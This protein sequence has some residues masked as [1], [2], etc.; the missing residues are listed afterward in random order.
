MPLLCL[1]W[2]RH[3]PGKRPFQ[4]ADAMAIAGGIGLVGLIDHMLVMPLLQQIA[5]L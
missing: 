5:I 2:L 4:A 3:I 1:Y